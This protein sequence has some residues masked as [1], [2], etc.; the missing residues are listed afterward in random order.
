MIRR[1]RAISPRRRYAFAAVIR[2]APHAAFPPA[3]IFIS[4]VMLG[5]AGAGALFKG[6]HRRLAAEHAAP[7]GTRPGADGYAPLE[8]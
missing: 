3:S 5:M 4:A 2:R 7:A 1:A 8:A 6:E